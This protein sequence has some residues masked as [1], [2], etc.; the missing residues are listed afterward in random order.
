MS[1]EPY[2]PNKK[3]EKCKKPFYSDDENQR[4]K[5]RRFCSVRCRN[6]A[7]FERRAKEYQELKDENQSLWVKITRLQNELDQIKKGEKNE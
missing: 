2:T 4:G 1:L 7:Y 5:P 3:C 6:L